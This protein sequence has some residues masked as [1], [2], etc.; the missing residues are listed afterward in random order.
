MDLSKYFQEI[1]REP[2]ITKEEEVELFEKYYLDST[3]KEEKELIRDRII[4]ANLRFA[5]KQAK[6][7]SKNDPT[8][9]EE[10]ISA[11]NEGLIVGFRKYNPSNG[12]RFLSYAGFWVHQRI[13]KEMSRMRIVS[14]PIWKQQLAARIQKE[15]DNNEKITLAEIKAKFVVPGVNVK[16]VEELFNTKFLTY[17]ISDLQEEEFL[18]D[19]IGEE[20]QKRVDE[21]RVWQAVNKLPSPH[22]EIIARCFGMED[23]EEQSPTK[24]ARALKVPK[25]DIQKLKEEGL[26]MLQDMLVVN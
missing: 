25:N 19:P 11:A 1:S 20:I 12:T 9:F 21:N 13:L 2:F 14:L 22:R 16:D 3:L 23:G 10:L 7:F 6:Y 4:R 8:V 18:V 24:I 26:A 17:Y 5:F 15:R